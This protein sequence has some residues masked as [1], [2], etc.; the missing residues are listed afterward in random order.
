MQKSTCKL[1]RRKVN[2][3]NF[4]GL[5][6]S[7]K[8]GRGKKQFFYTWF[9]T[10]LLCPFSVHG[11][12]VFHGGGGKG[13]KVGTNILISFLNRRTGKRKVPLPDHS[14]KMASRCN[15]PYRSDANILSCL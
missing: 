4:T 9:H 13:R 3:T 2:G 8:R 12:H 15:R 11:K 10:L 14:F 1:Y 6:L 5:F 7:D